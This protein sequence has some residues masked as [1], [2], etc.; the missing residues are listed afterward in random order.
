ML[1]DE[2]TARARLSSPRNLANLVRKNELGRWERRQ[3]MA[4]YA[5]HSGEANKKRDLATLL[6]D[7]AALADELSMWKNGGPYASD[8]LE[9]AGYLEGNAEDSE[10]TE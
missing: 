1:I 7:A 2:K 4:G 8:L 3:T 10:T 9:S 6:R 5:I